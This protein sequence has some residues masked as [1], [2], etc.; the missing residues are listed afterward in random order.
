MVMNVRLIPRSQQGSGQFNG[1]AILENKPV[2]FPGDG[3]SLNAFSNLFYWAHAWSDGGSTIGEHPHKGFEIL[4]FVLK[5]S[6]EHYDSHH[7]SWIPLQA[8]AAQVI[9]SGNGISH[10]ERLNAGAHMFQIWLDP[11]LNQ[12]LQK[13]A[14]Y[15]DYAPSAFPWQAE[16]GYEVKAFLGGEGAITLDTPGVH[17]REFRFE[18]GSHTWTLDAKKVHLTYLLSGQANWPDHGQ[19]QVDDAALLEG[20]SEFSFEAPEGAHFFVVSAPQQLS[21]RTYAEMMAA[22]I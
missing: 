4:S 21:Y 3:G 10:A 9:R 14:S 5:G 11:D 22:R 12:S 7:R 2:G 1:G 13:P 8:G 17:I 20:A 18:P 6:I 19:Q 15:S 16:N